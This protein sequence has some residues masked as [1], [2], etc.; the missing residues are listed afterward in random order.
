MATAMDSVELRVRALRGFPAHDADAFDAADASYAV[1]EVSFACTPQD[2]AAMD[3]SQAESPRFYHVERSLADFMHLEKRVF[4]SEAGGKIQ[5]AMEKLLVSGSSALLSMKQRTERL[6]W[7]LEAFL[8]DVSTALDGATAF[9]A[10]VH[11]HASLLHQDG[12]QERYHALIEQVLSSESTEKQEESLAGGCSMTHVES[13]T[14]VSSLVVWKFGFQGTAIDFSA[15]LQGE[16]PHN[17][18]QDVDPYSATAFAAAYAFPEAEQ[19]GDIVQYTTRYTLGTSQTV[20]GAFVAREKGALTFEWTNPDVDSIFSKALW[21]QVEVILLPSE[22]EAAQELEKLYE[23]DDS[24]ITWL[25]QVIYKHGSSKLVQEREENGMSA[26]GDVSDDDVTVWKYV[27]KPTSVEEV[28]PQPE[29]SQRLQNQVVKLEE[30]LQNVRLELK[31]ARSEL[32]IS[33]EVYKASLETIAHLE[34]P[35][36]TTPPSQLPADDVISY[37]SSEEDDEDED[38]DDDDDEVNDEMKRLRD[39]CATF[40]EQC[41]WRSIETSESEKRNLIL[42]GDLSRAEE[43][44]EVLRSKLATRDAELEEMRAE[45][46]KLKAQKSL[47]VKE[48]KRLQPFSQVNLTALVQDAEEARM[49]QRSLQAQLSALRQEQQAEVPAP[50]CDPEA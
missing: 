12:A 22:L 4:G 45:N 7:H 5:N 47:L 40:Q 11:P 43:K 31:A 38:D 28:P 17:E 14:S 2:D 46:Q 20:Y 49:M 34:A 44:V 10:F 41:L 39:L 42:E 37:H 3:A 27:S 1:V 36:R 24:D 35:V 25:E 6:M 19:D 9:Q 33:A 23:A 21:Y 16:D 50:E 32:D 13:I 18:K 8:I 26:S 15:R 29:Q 48:V 30:E